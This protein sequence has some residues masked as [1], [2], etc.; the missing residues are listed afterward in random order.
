MSTE[1]LAALREAV[2][3]VAPVL[4]PCVEWHRA[5]QDGYPRI[6]VNG[7]KMRVHRLIYAA[8][9]G[10]IPDGYI[11]HHI[12]ENKRC[13]NPEHLACMT[14]ATH[15]TMHDTA[16]RG[17]QRTREL[18]LART[19]CIHGHEF[20]SENT[21]RQNGGYRACRTC[22]KR[23]VREYLARKRGNDEQGS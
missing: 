14:R 19:H 6:R 12:C 15:L 2:P 4:S 20:T 16:Q 5:P 18:R 3:T 23:H 10:P 11:V 13:V 9:R 8:T 1:V 21:I 17:G 22:H 7:R